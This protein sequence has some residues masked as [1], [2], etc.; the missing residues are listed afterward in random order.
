VQCAYALEDYASLEQFMHQL[1]DGSPTLI[2][3]GEKLQ[4]GMW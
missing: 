4:S 3:I 2:D 1:P